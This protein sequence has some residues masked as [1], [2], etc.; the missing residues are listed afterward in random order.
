VK[1][2]LDARKSPVKITLLPSA[3]A[4]SGENASQYAT[5]YLINDHIAID[6][7]AIGFYRGPT[8]QAAI[9]HVFISHSHMDHLASL[10]IF[11]E[12]IADLSEAP[13]TLHA[14]SE[15][16]QSLREDL[17]NGRLWANFLELTHDDK[18][19]VNLSTIASGQTVVVEG[20]RITPICVNHVVPTLGF[21]L[22][23]AAA[24]VVISSDTGPTE[25]IWQRAR[26]TP[27]LKGVFL[28]ATFP[29]RMRHLAHITLHLTPSLFVEEMQKLALPVPFYAVH[30]KAS[31]R[32]QVAEELLALRLP[33]LEIA[34]FGTVY[35]F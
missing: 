30:L 35:E 23:D 31:F 6:A 21:I 2:H 5:S 17:F 24:A 13:V 10:P 4:A 11:L 29:D 15:V 25:E 27:N 1:F 19:F 9:R 26:R 28:E 12:N 7:G 33:N 8:E 22:E 18:P 16:Q 14:S 20:L 34:Q 3:V 32:E